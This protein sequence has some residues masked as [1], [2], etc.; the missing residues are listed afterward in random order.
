[1]V[2]AINNNSGNTTDNGLSD[3]T[4]TRATQTL[5]LVRLIVDD[6]VRLNESIEAQKDQLEGIDQLSATMD[7]Q[8]YV[9][10]L[11]DMRGML[12]GDIQRLQTC[13][14]ELA[15]LGVEVHQP[16]DG[17]VDFPAQLNRRPIRLCWHPAD[18][19]VEY[20]HELGQSADQRKKWD[21][22]AVGC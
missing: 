3:Y 18:E 12:D 20:W 5:P 14:D 4:P 8:A 6:L 10:E 7:R 15:R 22:A 2:R 1:M 16:F 9:D 21:A 17:F 19:K 11:S 13:I